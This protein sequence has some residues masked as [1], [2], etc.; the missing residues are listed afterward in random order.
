MV[1]KF[2]DNKIGSGMSVNKQLAEDVYKPAVKT[3]KRRKI[4]ARFKGN[5]WAADLA[6]IGSLSFKNKIVKYLLC[7]IDAFTKYAWVKPL[8]NKIR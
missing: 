8:K 1:Y 6:E 2:F 4:Y 5:I 3:F 7:V